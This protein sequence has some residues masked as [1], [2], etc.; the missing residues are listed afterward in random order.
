MVPVELKL[1]L[2]HTSCCAND[3]NSLAVRDIVGLGSLS[4][5]LSSR[6]G[7]APSVQHDLS[8]RA[9]SEHYLLQEVFSATLAHTLDPSDHLQYFNVSA[10]CA[11]ARKARD[12]DPN[13]GRDSQWISVAV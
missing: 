1:H 13:G 4:D 2:E 8:R 7:R 9:R 3:V 11:A 5:T 10:P 6:P 12:K